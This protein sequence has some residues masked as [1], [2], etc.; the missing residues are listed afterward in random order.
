M[1]WLINELINPMTY[2]FIGF[3]FLCIFNKKIP[4]GRKWLLYSIIFLIF[5][6]STTPFIPRQIAFSL[7]KKYNPLK[8][9]GIDTTM[10]YNVIVLGGGINVKPDAPPNSQLSTT[11]MMRLAE[12]IRICLRTSCSQLIT[13]G[14][15]KK[16][17]S[18][19]ETAANAA[20]VLGM[21]RHRVQF[22]SKA[23][24]TAEEA[25][26]YVGAF[27]PHKPLI[28]VTSALHM[29]RAVYL[30]KKAGVAH[31]YPAPTDYIQGQSAG[32]NFPVSFLP[33]I[34]NNFTLTSCF[35]EI[36]GLWYAKL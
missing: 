30:F 28:L 20:M 18:L 17:A 8:I 10:C 15:S 32:F 27:D 9:E 21:P 29:K 24:T 26:E 3:I 33:S 13:S 12:A 6:I 31:I 36:I 1:K 25:K 19:G 4:K 7:E 23:K 11:T 5:Y 35:H 16:S 22:L 34:N 14:Y 2:V